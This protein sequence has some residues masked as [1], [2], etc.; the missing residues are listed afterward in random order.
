M[1]LWACLGFPSLPRHTDGTG[2]VA[3]GASLAAS[4]ARR[5]PSMHNGWFPISFVFSLSSFPLSA[6]L[7]ARHTPFG[8]F[9]SQPGGAPKQTS[10]A[11]KSHYEPPLPHRWGAVWSTSHLGPKKKK[12]QQ[13]FA[14]LCLRWH[15][16][17][18]MSDV[19]WN[20]GTIGSFI[21][22]CCV[23]ERSKAGPL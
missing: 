18:L 22:Q 1:R 15:L 14:K 7:V 9:D 12:L 21:V 23:R 6:V 2:S 13:W 16:K 8:T 10:S 17:R 4:H 5:M 20:H 19:R 3:P 11:W